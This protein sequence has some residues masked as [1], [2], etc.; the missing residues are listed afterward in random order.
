[1]V[2]STFNTWTSMKL[3]WLHPKCPQCYANLNHV[4]PWPCPWHKDTP[5]GMFHGPLMATPQVSMVLCKPKPCNTMAMP[6]AQRQH[7]WH[8][9][10]IDTW[11]SIKL[12]W[13]HNKCPWCCVNMNN[14]APWPC[15]R[16]KDTTHGMFHP[17]THGPASSSH[18]YT[19]SVHGVMQI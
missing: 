12:P 10:P 11:T 15:P 8:V 17:Q 4:A 13:L 19:P 18:I 6:Q 1:M 2:C 5:H 14:V 3:L 7:T 16:H 9:P